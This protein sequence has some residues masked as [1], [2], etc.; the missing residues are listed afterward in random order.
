MSSSRRGVEQRVTIE[1]G[2][3]ATPE[4]P[5]NEPRLTHTTSAPPMV[6]AVGPESVSGGSMN[7]KKLLQMNR[8]R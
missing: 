8:M 3:L 1:A 4:M 7:L 2:E 6:G 5:I